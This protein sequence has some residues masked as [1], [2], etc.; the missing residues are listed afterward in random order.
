MK[1][2]KVVVYLLAILFLIC[3]TSCSSSGKSSESETMQS[4]DAEMQDKALRLADVDNQITDAVKK[5]DYTTALSLKGEMLSLAEELGLSDEYT[6]IAEK[7]DEAAANAGSDM[8]AT[9]PAMVESIDFALDD[10][11]IK[12]IGFEKANEKLTDE[13]N[14]LVFKYEFTNYQVKPSQVQNV[15]VIKY[16]QNGA[17]LSDRASWSSTGGDQYILVSDFF[18]E[19]LKDGTVTFG[20]IVVPKDTTPVTIMVRRNG[21]SD[22]EDS[23]QMMEVDISDS[24][25]KND[26]VTDVS[27]ETIQGALQG[28]WSMPNGSF[29]FD[30][31]DII[32]LSAGQIL[33]GTYDINTA[34]S[35]ID[36]DFTATNGTVT[37]HLP[38]KYENGELTVFNNAGEALTKE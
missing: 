5:G 13:K 12:Y 31:G 3:M 6:V 1:I 25:S 17:E 21:G 16:Y 18:S 36:A 28:T 38:Y 26:T 35:V 33:N 10:G 14:A 23:Y 9:D 32:C 29:A 2:K 19:A 30:N 27:S 20:Q 24:D 34:E 22:S 15:F 7:L 37:I 4:E 8:S 11:A